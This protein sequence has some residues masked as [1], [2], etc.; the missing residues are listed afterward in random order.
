[1]PILLVCPVVE[2][3]TSLG[4]VY[5]QFN[6][7]EVWKKYEVFINTSRIIS[8]PL[9]I[10]FFGVWGAL[11]NQCIYSIISFCFFNF[12]LWNGLISKEN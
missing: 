2:T 5:T 3:G 12:H 1:M 9:C 10:V 11:W 4:L 7:I 6:A 8:M